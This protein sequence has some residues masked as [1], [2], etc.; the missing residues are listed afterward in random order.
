MCVKV[1]MNK[2]RT[3]K[4]YMKDTI[5]RYKIYTHTHCSS[6]HYISTTRKTPIAEARVSGLFL[7]MDLSP[8]RL[9]C[10]CANGYVIQFAP[11]SGLALLSCG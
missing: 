5:A 7:L 4:S 2:P 9:L 1:D 11:V 3:S 10:V 8:G 6:S